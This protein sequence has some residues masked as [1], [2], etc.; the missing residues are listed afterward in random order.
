[1][2]DRL[3]MMGEPTNVN[4]IAKMVKEEIEELGDKLHDKFGKKQKKYAYQ[5]RPQEPD[6]DQTM[7]SGWSWDFSSRPKEKVEAPYNK[8]DFV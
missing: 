2:S 6:Q 4:N 5:Q 8:K 1:M 3:A 7:T